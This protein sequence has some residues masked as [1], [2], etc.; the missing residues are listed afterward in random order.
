MV[1]SQ[2]TQRLIQQYQSWYQSL[3]PKEGAATIHVDEVA[4]RVANFYEKIRGLL[5]WK[6]EHLLRRA[7]IRR[8]LRRKL[9]LRVEQKIEAQ[10][11]VLELIRAGHFPN[12]K[13]EESK[14]G[15][16]QKLLNKYI[17]IIENS[18]PPKKKKSQVQLQDWLSGLAACEIEEV[19]DPLR[20]ERALIEYMTDLMA[21]RIPLPQVLSEEEKNS[22]IYIAVQKAL[23]KLDSPII[24]YHLLK[25]RY[26]QWKDLPQDQL[27]GITKNIYTIWSTIENDFRHP[28][29][30]KFYRICERYDTPYLILGD[31]LSKNPTEIQEKLSNPE[32]L[33]SSIRIVYKTRLAKL[34]SRLFRAATLSTVSIFLTKI[35]IAL[36]IEFPF[37]KYI[38]QQFSYQTLGMNILI[39]PFLMFFLVLSARPPR[40]G[41]LEKVIMETMKIVYASGKKDIFKIKSSFKRG[42][43][44]KIVIFLLY[45]A[46]FIASFWFI[47]WGLDKLHFSWPS[48]I[49]FII[50]FSLISFAGVKIKERV[51]ELSVEEEGGGFLGFILDW[52]S[53]PFIR[54]GKWL[55]G[56]WERTNVV[57][58]LLMIT[59]LID[60][61][62]QVFVEFLEQWR[63]FIKEKKEEIH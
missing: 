5:D 25:K 3:Q 23:F 35:L 58:V 22:Q 57:L 53:L 56:Q 44:M 11:L 43:L 63:Y 42:F 1:I 26:P 4:S 19:L 28:L 27:D 12:D 7:A 2:Q 10:P 13:I 18:L 20:K 15:D 8:I 37:D 45:L 62:F 21:E 47:W 49:I 33:E 36:A 34:K 16:V 40:K 31:V 48:K 6:E 46:T 17:F 54:L 59:A 55:S 14:I 9:F 51:K 39:P 61:P 38:T 32:T 29:G 50:F 41:N 52:F 60:L 24:S 30:E